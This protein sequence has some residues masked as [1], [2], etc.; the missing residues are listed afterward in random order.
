MDRA[1]SRLARLASLLPQ[2][3]AAEFPTNLVNSI[4]KI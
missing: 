3:N 4:S 2:T 1:A